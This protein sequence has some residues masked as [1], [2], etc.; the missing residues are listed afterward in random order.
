MILSASLPKGEAAILERVIK[1]R[2]TVPVAAARALLRLEFDAA[3]RQQMHELAQKNQEGSLT[4]EEQ[5]ELDDYVRIGL[6]LDLLRAKALRSIRRR[7]S[8]RR[9]SDG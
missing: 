2:V 8:R 1:P 6:V 9:D 4:A 5:T 3:D 7:P